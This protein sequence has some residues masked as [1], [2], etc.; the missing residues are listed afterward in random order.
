[1]NLRRRLGILTPSDSSPKRINSSIDHSSL[2]NVMD[3]PWYVSPSGS[4]DIS[5][6]QD[7]TDDGTPFSQGRRRPP[8]S[9][10]INSMLAHLENVQPG[11]MNRLRQDF[12]WL[13]FEM[14]SAHLN[15]EDARFLL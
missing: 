4:N 14:E 7:P 1:M 8:L 12:A 2:L 15:P 11:R 5:I 10:T 9:K 13:Q 6:T 3:E